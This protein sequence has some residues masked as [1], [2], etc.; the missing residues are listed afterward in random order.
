MDTSQAAQE[1]AWSRALQ[2]A[3][4]KQPPSRTTLDTKKKILGEQLAA[5]KE[6]YLTLI[7]QG[8]KQTD[9]EAQ[10][11]ILTRLRRDQLSLELEAQK[12][13][14]RRSLT[15]EDITPLLQSYYDECYALVY[16]LAHDYGKRE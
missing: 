12:N 13:T 11:Y 6:V 4:Q 5:Q 1:Q 7:K 2:Q 3:L 8:A 9:V 15:A 10:A 14:L 16:S